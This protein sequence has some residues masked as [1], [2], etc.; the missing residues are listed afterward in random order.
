MRIKLLFNRLI[1]QTFR[2]LLLVAGCWLLVNSSL[3]AQTNGDYRSV[4]DGSWTTLA[5]W[6]RYSGGAWLIPDAGQGYPG[7]NGIPGRID[8]NNNINLNVSPANPLGNLYINTG[9]LE[10][11]S[12]NL[13]VN[14]TTNIFGTF[15]DTDPNGTVIF[16]GNIT[17][18]NSGIWNSAAGKSDRLRLY[19]NIINNSTNVSLTRVRVYSNVTL[20]G[21]GDIDISEYFEFQ[22]NYTVTNQTKITIGIGLNS[23]NTFN[24]TL[25]NE[26]ELFYA[27]TTDLL[28]GTNGI[29]NA[30]SAGN[31]IEYNGAGA[32]S[33]KLPSTTYY[34][35]T[36][37]NSGT[38]SLRGNTTI[39]GDLTIGS[40]TILDVTASNYSI[41][42]LGNWDNQGSFNERLGT[43]TFSGGNSQ[44]I[45][46]TTAPETF[47]YLTINKSSNEVTLLDNITVRTIL[48]IQAGT[49][50]TS[51][52]SITGDGS[53]TLNIASGATLTLGNTSVATSVAF[54]TNF[55]AYTLNANSTVIYQA[56]TNQPVSNVTSY[57]NL[58]T[59]TS[60]SKTLQGNITINGNLLIGTGSTLDVSSGNNYTITLYGNWAHQG[61]FEERQGTVIFT[62]S[63]TQTITSAFSPE[64]FY[65][66][67]VN[68]T[69]G[70]VQ[71]VN[72]AQDVRAYN[73][74]SLYIQQGTYET[75][76]SDLIVTG[77]T[78]IAGR[79]STNNVSGT[80]SLI[81]VSFSGTT[82][83]IGS[84]TNTGTVNISGTLAASSGSGTIGR[85]NL[86]VTGATTISATRSLTFN[87]NNGIKI[88]TGLV[89]N[90]GTWNNSAN[91]DITFRGG[92]TNSGTSFLSGTGTYSFTTNTQTLNGTTAITFDGPVT[93]SSTLNNSN[94]TTINGILGGNGT[95]TNSNGSVLNY[96]N[97][98]A[99]MLSG[100]FNVSANSNTVNYTRT[101]G[102][103]IRDVTYFNLI[104]SGGGTKTLL[105]NTSVNGTLTMT[106]GNIV[107]GA[108]TL[109]L[110]NSS[111]ASLSYSSGIIVGNFERFINQT[112]LDY[113]FPVGIAAQI[114]SLTIRFQNLTSGSLLVNYTQNDPGNTG[115]PLVDNDGSEIG[116]QYTTG[117]WTA[118]AKN[119][120]ATSNYRI[121][122]EAAGFGPYSIDTW[123]RVITRTGTGPW[124][125]DGN[126]SDAT[127]TVIKR[128][129][130]TKGI[131]GAAAGTQFGAGRPKPRIITQPVDQIVC[132]NGTTV[133]SITATGYGTLTYQ[134]YKA[135]A[136]LLVNGGQFSGVSTNSLTIS[137]V[138]IGDA[139]SYYCIVTDGNG[140]TRQSNSASLTV[141][142]APTITLDPVSAVC[143]TVNSFNLPYSGTANNP[144]TYS[145]TTGTPA[146]P[147][148]SPVTDAVLSGSPITVTI[149]TGIA[150]NNYQFII[151]VKN[152][153]GCVSTAKNFTVNVYENQIANAGPDQNICGALTSVFAGNVPA[154]GTGTWS[155]VSGPDP[156]PTYGNINSATSSI[157]VD[158]YGT[159][160]FRWTLVNGACQTQDDVVI[161]FNEDPAG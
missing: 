136:T 82:G 35:L 126:H 80:A 39:N 131:S 122:L 103:N 108:N 81:N 157:A 121:N 69:G 128:N 138:G 22:N 74:G 151:T 2:L 154:K 33:I 160:T 20:S 57:G 68:K 143:N 28:M 112:I 155:L 116:E 6:Q 1:R 18:S 4:A 66:I 60:G 53:G 64:D 144:T 84:T 90:N 117:Y 124:E 89:T 106:A 42:I 77:S 119:S 92:L 120:L 83:L 85:V 134:W 14:G 113:L 19:A 125:I 3:S 54:P 61:T 51:V 49:L 101:T 123:T 111:A 55:S 156:S 93:V 46:I 10:L 107:T 105:G 88:F 72:D 15:S 146:M 96:D 110:N 11:S 21:S 36:T 34:N 148:F 25:I 58:I 145:I 158:Y 9:T 56:N 13:T 141:N 43:V 70:V 24:A 159:Y 62:G 16:Y 7:Q 149:P 31:T 139:G 100:T 86:N 142:P 30:S 17:V 41:T 12:Y 63:N 67:T 48:D 52:N 147:G 94:T 137:P 127:G 5:N 99:P 152:G 23:N 95:W 133:F 97:A 27:G 73:G 91:E 130:L 65:N 102:Q 87:D 50:A 132:E 135:P 59:A 161:D 40:G 150:E 78:T 47:Y 79:L 104:T 8:I 29:L 115:L 114:H 98:T 109:L 45:N 153:N 129:G 38:K 26:G 75:N 71:P 118:Q 140:N 32:Q 44:T 76:G 37:S